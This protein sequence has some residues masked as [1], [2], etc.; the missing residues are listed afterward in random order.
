MYKFKVESVCWSNSVS[1][2]KESGSNKGLVADEGVLVLL[3]C[4]C[5]D[6]HDTFHDTP[7]CR[8]GD[9]KYAH[10]NSWF[11]CLWRYTL[12]LMGKED[13]ACEISPRTFIV[14]S[15]NKCTQAEGH[16]L[17][18]TFAWQSKSRGWEAR[19]TEHGELLH[20][21]QIYFSLPGFPYTARDTSHI[22]L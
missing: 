22:L 11:T 7:D 12:C 4:C 10:S 17:R 1:R 3:P 18:E 6:F 15:R 8:V 5:G 16:C 13:S 19:G 2:L 21:I 20:L 14:D 9:L